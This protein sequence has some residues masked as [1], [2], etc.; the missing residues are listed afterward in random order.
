MW[1][2]QRGGCLG[3]LG[4]PFCSLLDLLVGLKSASL[5]SCWRCPGRLLSWLF[6]CSSIVSWL[7]CHLC[8][9]FSFHFYWFW[10][11]CFLASVFVVLE[12]SNGLRVVLAMT[13]RR[14]R[15]G[16]T[17][18]EC[19]TWE[20][21]GHTFIWIDVSISQFFNLG[22]PI[23]HRSPIE[24]IRPRGFINRRSDRKSSRGPQ[25]RRPHWPMGRS[26]SGG[27]KIR[28]EKSGDIFRKCQKKCSIKLKNPSGTVG[29]IS[30]PRRGFFRISIGNRQDLIDFEL[31]FCSDLRS[32]IDQKH[33][34][35][36]PR[37]NFWGPQKIVGPIDFDLA[38]DRFWCRRDQKSISISDLS[39]IS[40]PS[41][42]IKG[43][44]LF[45][46]V[47]DPK[48]ISNLDLFDLKTLIQIVKPSQSFTQLLPFWTF[49]RPKIDF[50]LG[51][52]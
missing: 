36:C 30:G 10:L 8:S 28:R 7:V 43:C 52:L 42:T 38:S 18:W 34:K 22:S 29:R 12:W 44:A 47:R 15:H 37:D 48:F 40:K 19:R 51:S 49:R 46:P 39:S 50:R 13:G 26:I 33:Q 4:V 25:N 21:R 14:T 2:R 20:Y 16:Q 1:K 45:F 5:R 35:C 32:Q 11:V 27:P 23:R 17:R 6:L 3:P 31:G 24:T 9:T 41:F